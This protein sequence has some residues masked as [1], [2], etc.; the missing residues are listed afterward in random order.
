MNR[1]VIIFYF[2]RYKFTHTFATKTTN[3]FGWAELT[4]KAGVYKIIFHAINEQI[5]G[6]RNYLKVV[7]LCIME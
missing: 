6:Y 3:F 1:L 2:L 5:I 7:L 4:N